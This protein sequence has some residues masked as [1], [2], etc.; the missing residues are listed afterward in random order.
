MQD[1]KML[2]L[3]LTHKET[4]KTKLF[5]FCEPSENL[6]ISS[7]HQVQVNQYDLLRYIKLKHRQQFQLMI[8]SKLCQSLINKHYLGITVLQPD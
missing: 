7:I 4:Y 1:T 8:F 6:I 5:C 3:L 2:K